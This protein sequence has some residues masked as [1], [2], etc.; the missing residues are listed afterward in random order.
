MKY[1]ILDL[2]SGAGGMSKGMDM[3]PGFS[4][5]V[6]T[7]FN[8]P[9]LDTFKYNFPKADIVYG[10]ILDKDVKEKIQEKAEKHGVNMIIG[11]PPCQGFSNK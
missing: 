3:V 5:V 8:K 1:N 9:A 4:T 11:G 6:A 10:D 7:D 2:F